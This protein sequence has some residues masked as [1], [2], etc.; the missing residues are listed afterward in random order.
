MSTDGL[1]YMPEEFRESARGSLESADAA[2]STRR[3]LGTAQPDAGRF[4]GADAFV[5]ALVST[6]D[7][8]MREVEQAAE[9]REEMAGAD[10]RTADIGEEMESAAESA[11]TRAHTAVARAIADGM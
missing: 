4:G 5:G 11:L 2:E 1:F 9:G 3:R 8:Q 7:R 10:Q 6:R